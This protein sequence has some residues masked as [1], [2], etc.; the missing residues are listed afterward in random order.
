M[1]DGFPDGLPCGGTP[2]HHR[3]E[4]TRHDDLGHIRPRDG[5]DCLRERRTLALNG[6][7]KTPYDTRVQR[8]ARHT[9]AAAAVDGRGANP[10]VSRRPTCTLIPRNGTNTASDPGA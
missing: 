2:L 7:S 10:D 6:R 1:A 4:V 8:P 9:L 3:D 5:E